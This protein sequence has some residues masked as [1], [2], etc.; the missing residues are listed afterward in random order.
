VRFFWLGKKGGESSSLMMTERG[1]RNSA[2]KG[3]QLNY[4]EK[5]K[6][7]LERDEPLLEKGGNNWRGGK[8]GK[9]GGRFDPRE[10]GGGKVPDFEKGG[11]KREKIW[12]KK[13]TV[14]LR[15]EEGKKKRGGGVNL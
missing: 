1:K 5:G 7:E 14:E 12:K 10:G 4:L 6:G 9:R 2:E 11:G 8:G 13:K 3:G 15:D